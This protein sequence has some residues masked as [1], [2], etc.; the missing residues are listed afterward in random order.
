MD[1]DD[2]L[3]LRRKLMS[4][5]VRRAFELLRSHTYTTP[6]DVPHA[7][8]L[9]GSTSTATDPSLGDLLEG[10][11]IQP[12][13][14]LIAVTEQGE[15]VASVLPDG[16]VH[17]DEETFGSL[18]ELNDSLGIEE[19]PWQAWAADLPDGRVRLAVLRDQLADVTE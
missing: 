9:E 17:F 11:L 19:S 4:D 3:Q 16:R 7:G 15:L 14:E 10:D 12:G 13:V 5:V 1:Y 18:L 8:S 2:F 6:I